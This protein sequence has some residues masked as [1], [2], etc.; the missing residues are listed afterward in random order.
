MSKTKHGINLG[1]RARRIVR[2]AARFINPVVLLIAGRR[3]MPILGVLHHRGRQ[4]GRH[5]LPCGLRPG[6]VA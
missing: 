2:S 1:P 6:S 5:P 3:W 4:S